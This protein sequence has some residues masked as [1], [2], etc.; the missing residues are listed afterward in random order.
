MRRVRGGQVSIRYLNVTVIDDMAHRPR[1]CG[2]VSPERIESMPTASSTDA[3]ASCMDD[4]DCVPTTHEAACSALREA[5][6]C[7]THLPYLACVACTSAHLSDPSSH[8]S[9]SGEVSQ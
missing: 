7:S 3:Q 8:V 1:H 9:T 5:Y 4:E 2:W 6:L